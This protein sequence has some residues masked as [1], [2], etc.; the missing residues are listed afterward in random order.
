MTFLFTAKFVLLFLVSFGGVSLTAH[1]VGRGIVGSEGE[2][3]I[4]FE[5]LCKRLGGSKLDFGPWLSRP[6]F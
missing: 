4:L 5:F 1:E 2:L 3:L 6:G